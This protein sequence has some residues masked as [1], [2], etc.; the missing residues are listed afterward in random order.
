MNYIL[1]DY[2]GLLLHPEL[3]ALH[4]HKSIHDL[5]PS[6]LYKIVRYHELVFSFR[7]V[8]FVLFDTILNLVLAMPLGFDQLGH[9]ML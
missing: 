1:L 4:L 7:L 9:Q 6:C 5:L 3:L 8:G 2:R